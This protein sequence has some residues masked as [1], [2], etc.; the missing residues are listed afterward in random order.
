MFAP[1]DASLALHD[2]LSTNTTKEKPIVA[3]Q[4]II[5][6]SIGKKIILSYTKVMEYIH[7]DAL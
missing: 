1:A 2:R 7:F 5:L 4:C 6:N 3:I